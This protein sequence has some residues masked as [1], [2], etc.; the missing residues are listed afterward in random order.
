M[1]KLILT[2]VALVFATSFAL[3]QDGKKSL[4]EA[5][6]SLSKYTSDPFGNAGALDEALANLESAFQDAAISSDVKSWLTRG[7]IFF[8]IADSQN[9]NKLINPD[10]A[11]TN[12]QA[13]M[14]ALAAYEKA[15]EMA[16]KKGDK[17][18]AIKGIKSLEEV[19]NN[20]GINLYQS[21]DFL[22]AY[23]NFN[24]ELH[25]QDLLKANGEASRLDGEGLLA[26]KLYFAGLTAFYAQNFEDSA[27]K[28]KKTLEQNKE[29]GTLYQI[30]FEALNKIGKS[31]EAFSYLEKG[32]TKFPED[33]GLL[34]SEINY[35]LQQ[36]K[37][38][39]M[40]SKLE[41]ALA[42]EPDN[43]SVILTLGQVYDQLQVKSNEAG[44]LVKGQEY[45]EKALEYYQ[46]ALAVN[47]E[48]FDQNYSIAA[49]YYNRAAGL[50]PSLNEA[51]NDFS[52]AGS[53]KYDAIKE[54]M[55]TYFD[56][57][58]PYFLKAESLKSTDRNT[59]IALKEIYVRKDMF[60]KS[61]EYKERLEALNNE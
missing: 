14:N 24:A 45:F 32:R 20:L 35:Y 21:E 6:K 11:I 57:A 15:L 10:F 13:G 52:A 12:P 27:A 38:A 51:A 50:T 53:K 59:L 37:L 3:A 60:E 42:K 36:G 1:N 26:D 41:E 9:K 4:K 43:I 18:D 40:I 23:Q 54:E 8:N 47:P 44:D 46:K 39:E 29:E 19:L 25:A 58:L 2:L 22:G 34:F 5:S 28:L 48:S 30:L 33:S 7:E 61:N 31:D 17:K 16:E 56:K 49:L 55:S